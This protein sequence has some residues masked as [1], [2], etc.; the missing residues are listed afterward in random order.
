MNKR[1]YLSVVTAVLLSA[2]QQSLQDYVPGTY[3]SENEG[4]FSI[5]KDTL[6]ISMVDDQSN[7][8][9]IVKNSAYRKIRNGKLKP[10]EFDSK[11]WQGTYDEKSHVLTTSPE[12]KSF[13][14]FPEKRTLMLG[15]REYQKIEE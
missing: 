15:K 13:L 8:Y 10:Q 2:C 7:A 6:V 11:T 3:V 12:V 9:R 1:I 5:S 14:F 4:Q